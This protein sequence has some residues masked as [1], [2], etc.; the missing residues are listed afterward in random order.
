M[1][2]GTEVSLTALGGLGEF[3]RNVLWL[4]CGDSNLLV[5]VG[6][7]FP[8]ET[9]PGIDRIAPD[10][11]P[12]R[13][14]SIDAILL[15]HGHEDHVGA[16]PLL[17]EWCDAPVYALPFTVAM[18]R[19][20][21]EEAGLSAR[22]TEARGGEKV[23]AGAFAFTFFRVSHS[24]PDSAAL[25]IEAAGLRIFHS[26][27]FKLDPDPPDGETTDV[28]GITKA[29]GEGVDLALVDSTNAERP[30][31]ALSERVAG[32]GLADAFEGAPG[33][34][35]LTTFSS[36]VARI[37]QAVEAATSL[38]R[39][40]AM[41]GRS[42]RT[43]AEIAE[44]FGRLRIPAQLR[45][46]SGELHSVPAG[47]V[48]CLTSGSQGEPFSALYRLALD[49]HADMKLA[50][51]DLVLFSSRT[52]PGHERSVNRVT[53]HLVRRGAR[54]LRE[55]EPPI[56]VSGH[57]H[58]EDIA[59]WLRM[60]RPKAVVPIHGEV[61]MLAA[62]AQVARDSGVA[63]DRAPLLDNGD[64]L[65]L[66]AGGIRV[67]RGAVPTGRIFL[68]S[69]P[70]AVDLDIVRD[71]RRLAEEGFI[72]VFVHDREISV[73]SRGVARDEAGLAGEVS[74]AAKEVLERATPEESSDVEW[75]RSEIALAAKR[76]CRREFGIRPVIVPVIV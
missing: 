64:R 16:L 49:E 40:I 61:R 20:R 76:V 45:I 38:G 34:I 35:I 72:V 14:L 19:R 67:E 21:L 54:V 65:V 71:R 62:A 10:L 42:M 12:L 28:T 48:L 69:R 66:S 59:E 9:F 3:G 18:A 27:D 26:G 47:R 50:R 43:V 56:H 7:S 24:V 23:S 33:R 46:A 11:S 37:S 44:R 58:S 70:E 30:G 1:T 32:R 52:I 36:H 55:T 57:A 2:G 41:L 17:S 74:R 8:D 4:S 15:T 5:D 60:L 29:V 53:D 22:L 13:G 6:V 31:R 75:L 39:R 51:G 73:V 68:D 25:L 63:P